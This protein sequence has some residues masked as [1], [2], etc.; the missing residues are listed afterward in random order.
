MAS[1]DRGR[2]SDERRVTRLARIEDVLE[3]DEHADSAE[4]QLA[5]QAKLHK[6]ATDI[7]ERI[8]LEPL[9]ASVERLDPDPP[10]ILD[11]P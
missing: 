7:A 9:F 4:L 2:G 11:L 5:R 6:G 10:S 1:V 8:V 3:V